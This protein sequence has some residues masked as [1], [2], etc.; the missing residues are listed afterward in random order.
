MAV[1]RQPNAVKMTAAADQTTEKL[2]VGQLIWTG[3]TIATDA[4][5][6]QD[7]LGTELL[8]VVATA[9]APFQ[10]SWPFGNDNLKN[11]LKVATMSA[12]Q[13]ELILM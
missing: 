9:V 10:I 11:G 8:S 7:T 2:R 5:V 6:I 1:T 12:G 3:M 13:I 4:L